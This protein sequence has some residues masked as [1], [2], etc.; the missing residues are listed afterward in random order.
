MKEFMPYI[1][2]FLAI[3]IV[4]AILR[5]EPSNTYC[6]KFVIKHRNEWISDSGTTK[7][8]YRINH[9]DKKYYI[10]VT[11]KLL[12]DDAYSIVFWGDRRSWLWRFRL[13][14][15]FTVDASYRESKHQDV[16]LDR[17]ILQ[18]IK[19]NDNGLIK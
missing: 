17:Q 11:I 7:G 3:M 9:T 12:D 5:S 13:D 16:A 1:L 14:K 2:I 8:Y 6:K 4:Y 18:I 15:H 10:D 19:N